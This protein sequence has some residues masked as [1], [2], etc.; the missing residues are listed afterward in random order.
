MYYK[1]KRQI[2]I[3]G[4]SKLCQAAREKKDILEKGACNKNKNEEN[5]ILGAEK[6][7]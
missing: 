7:G 1:Q 3:K 6:R 4:G 2:F 5:Y